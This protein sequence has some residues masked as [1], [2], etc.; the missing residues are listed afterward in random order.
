M[1]VRNTRWSLDCFNSNN[2]LYL[3]SSLIILKNEY[4]HQCFWQKYVLY[5]TS[6]SNGSFVYQ[7]PMRAEN[8]Q[9]VLAKLR[10]CYFLLSAFK[11]KAFCTRRFVKLLIVRIHYGFWEQLDP[12]NIPNWLFITNVFCRLEK[13]LN[14]YQAIVIWQ[15]NAQT[16]HRA[17][18]MYLKFIGYF[19]ILLKLF[20][21]YGHVSRQKIH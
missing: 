21:C 15:Q 10:P 20:L 7:K 12:T 18:F 14:Y 13:S 9:R 2:I 16:C 4:F 5:W 11:V 19:F 3:K 17:I 1:V 8:A 6:K